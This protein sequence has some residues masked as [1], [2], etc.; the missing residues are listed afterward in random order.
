MRRNFEELRSFLH[1]HY[2]ALK[3][4]DSIRGELYPPPAMADAIASAGSFMQMGG[5]A[6][7]VGGPFI[8]QTMG[9]PEPAF[10]PMLTNNKAAVIIG[11]VVVNSICSSFRST[12]AF[13]V[14]I[15]G[16]LVFS[17]IE[18]KTFPTGARLMKEFDSRGVVRNHKDFW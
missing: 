7:A 17:K 4:A 13:E 15:D 8:F 9:I 12:G 18:E 10:L 16:E 14:T 11:L 6:L 2:P 1:H 3:A 5:V